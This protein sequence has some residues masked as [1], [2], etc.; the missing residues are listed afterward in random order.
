MGNVV[1]MQQEK[2]LNNKNL[3]LDKE[4]PDKL[5]AYRNYVSESER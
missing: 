2:Y 4:K 1:L 3:K 5:A